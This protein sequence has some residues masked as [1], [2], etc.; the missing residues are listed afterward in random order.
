M[1][2]VRSEPEDVGCSGFISHS[3]L[4]LCDSNSHL[5]WAQALKP[6][7]LVSLS[8][9]GQS[10]NHSTLLCNSFLHSTDR[11]DTLPDSM[12]N[13][14]WPWQRDFLGINDQLGR[15]EHPTCL[16]VFPGSYTISVIIVSEPQTPINPQGWDCY[17]IKGFCLFKSP[18][19]REFIIRGNA[20]SFGTYWACFGESVPCMVSQSD[21]V[22]KHLN[23]QHPKVSSAANH[24]YEL[25]G[26][27]P[28]VS[29][30][31]SWIIS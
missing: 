11:T 16:P 4:E 1:D 18:R 7:C 3:G 21:C 19:E 13:H 26:C 12:S 2:H 17:K 24:L 9:T 31:C 29:E 6:F 8:E 10:H 20:G 27:V 25:P 28:P 5:E 14:K 23:S 15:N 30:V 22:Q